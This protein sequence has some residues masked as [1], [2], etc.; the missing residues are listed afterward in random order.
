MYNKQPE[1]LQKHLIIDV[2]VSSN[3]SYFIEMLCVLPC[4]Y[5]EQGMEK[6]SNDFLI[7]K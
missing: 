5:Y 6:V 2:L 3:L 1:D 4:D 7:G